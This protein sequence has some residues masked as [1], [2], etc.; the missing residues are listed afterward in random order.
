M[1]LVALCLFLSVKAQRF[2]GGMTFGIT[3]AQIDGDNLA[4]FNK[5]GIHFGA[6]TNTALSE[7][8][9]IQLEMKYCNRG[10]YGNRGTKELPNIYKMV[11]NYFDVP[12][13]IQYYTSDDLYFE[14]G[15]LTGFLL[16]NKMFD[17]GG[18]VPQS[19]LDAIGNFNDQDYNFFAGFGIEM[20]EKLTFNMRYAY[21]IVPARTR[22]TGG[23]YYGFW[24]RL[25]GYTEGDYNNY[26][27]LGFNWKLN[28]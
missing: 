28:E 1:L 6:Y 20:N 5:V 9:L 12:L 21:S 25:L 10:A 26:V 19:E 16:S 24:Q 4:G 27:T 14:G 23:Y 15:F 17:G 11:L 2:D 13:G 3:A 18:R 7:K 8:V 22:L